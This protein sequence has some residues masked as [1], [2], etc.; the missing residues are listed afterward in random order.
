MHPQRNNGLGETRQCGHWRGLT[1]GILGMTNYSLNHMQSSDSIIAE[2]TSIVN[3]C[4]CIDSAHSRDLYNVISSIIKNTSS[5]LRVYIF[6]DGLPPNDSWIKASS[7]L[8]EMSGGELNLNYVDVKSD[9]VPLP[10]GSP[11]ISKVARFK[12]LMSSIDCDKLL[13]L[14]TD[15]LVQS[16]IHVLFSFDLENYPL[17]ACADINSGPFARRLG[18]GSGSKYFNS[19]V[20]LVNVKLWRE[21]CIA[22]KLKKAT[23]ENADI[24]RYV[25]QDAFNIVFAGLGF[26]LIPL[27][28]NLPYNPRLSV[29]GLLVYLL[30][31]RGIYS[32]HSVLK[33]WLWPAIVH[34]IGKPKPSE[35]RLKGRLYRNY[36]FSAK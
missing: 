7:R 30:R 3:I 21:K 32:I 26:L 8:L 22:E 17:G 19:G 33:A 2:A 28:W 16:D 36:Y 31:F 14:D 15:I 24:I 4:F 11:H 5:A 34:F 1:T 27:K 23:F 20:L 10:S 35:S 9:L 13:Y 29:G 18:L 12:F 25:D 6:H